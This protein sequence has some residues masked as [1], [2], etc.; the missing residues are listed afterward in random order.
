MRSHAQSPNIVNG[1]SVAPTALKQ[2]PSRR[3]WVSTRSIF[4]SISDVTI[5]NCTVGIGFCCTTLILSVPCH[6]QTALRTSRM[7]RC[8][9]NRCRRHSADYKRVWLGMSRRQPREPA[10]ANATKSDRGSKIKQGL[11]KLLDF[12]SLNLPSLLTG[13]EAQH[14]TR[15]GEQARPPSPTQNPGGLTTGPPSCM[16]SKPACGWHA[17]G[18]PIRH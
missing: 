17:A 10:A 1:R 16:G 8:H 13:S 7:A 9:G 18:W 6:A 4:C 14:Q 11:E 15:A 2:E 12:S 5:R 3:R